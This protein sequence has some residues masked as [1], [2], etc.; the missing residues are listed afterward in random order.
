M[1]GA[2]GGLALIVGIAAVVLKRRS[3][4][5]KAAKQRG[6]KSA[7]SRYSAHK[8]RGNQLDAGVVYDKVRV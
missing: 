1:S 6:T 4:A 7:R 8:A 3:A 2:V 5:V